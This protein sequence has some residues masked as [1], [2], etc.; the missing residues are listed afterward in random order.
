ME[1]V[2]A[3]TLSPMDMLSVMRTT[4][5]TYSG[6]TVNERLVTSGLMSAWDD[7][8]RNGQRPAAIDL[9]GQVDL[10]DQAEEV[11]DMVLGDPTTYGFPPTR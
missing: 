2:S 8:I 7:A 11:V 5:P 9:L 1:R 3:A 4:E 6:M 10:T